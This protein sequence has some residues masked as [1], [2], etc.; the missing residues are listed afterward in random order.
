MHLLVSEI[1]DLIEKA[2]TK[3][4]KV[5]LLKQYESAAT[6]LIL[7]LNF[8]PNLNMG[9]PEGE[10]PYKKEVDKPSGYQ[11]TNLVKEARRFYIWLD[12]KTQLP[13]VRKEKLFI[14]MLEG[15]HFSEADVLCLVKD[16]NLGKKYPSIKEGIVREAYP[17]LLPPEVIKEKKSLN[18]EASGTE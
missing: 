8:D 13:K 11:E 10:P 18:S 17:G 3:Q 16:R 12:P 6:R 15:L 1:F 2:K 7:R 4:E 5:G 14:E 9:L